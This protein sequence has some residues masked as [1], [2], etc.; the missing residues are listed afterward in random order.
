[1]LIAV[2]LAAAAETVAVDEPIAIDVEL[3]PIFMFI[4][5]PLFRPDN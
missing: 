5:G 4:G 3:E 1:M 2:L